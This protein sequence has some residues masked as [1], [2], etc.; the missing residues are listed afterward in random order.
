MQRVLPDELHGMIHLL[1]S[2]VHR[3]Y[4][5]WIGTR[6]VLQKGVRDTLSGFPRHRVG[7]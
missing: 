6:W 7:R 1:T 4:D 3:S 5:W 2:C